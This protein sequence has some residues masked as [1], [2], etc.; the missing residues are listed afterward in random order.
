VGQHTFNPAQSRGFSE[1]GWVQP[2][3]EKT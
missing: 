1:P 2:I 3:F